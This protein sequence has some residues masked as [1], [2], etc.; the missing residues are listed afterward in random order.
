MIHQHALPQKKT[1]ARRG[2]TLIELLV[3]IAIIGILAGLLLPA[4]AKAKENANMVSGANNMKQIGLAVKLYD[5]REQT[6]PVTSDANGGGDRFLQLLYY[7]GDQPEVKVFKTKG[8]GNLGGTP[9]KTVAWALGGVY[10]PGMCGYKSTV[11]TP[12]GEAEN[13]S[14][15]AIACDTLNAA[16]DAPFFKKGTGGKRNVLY[17]DGSVRSQSDVIVGASNG[18]TTVADVDKDLR[19]LLLQ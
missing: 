16:G 9:A 8:S 4:L 3:V 5:S 13:P 6:Y 15:C 10:L 19:M 18:A 14:S 11:T 17:S 1:G 12:L 2:F 7:T